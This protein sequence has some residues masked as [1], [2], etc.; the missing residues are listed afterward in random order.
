M[1]AH[2]L[3]NTHQPFANNDAS[4]QIDHSSYNNHNSAWNAHMDPNQTA[5][6]DSRNNNHINDEYGHKKS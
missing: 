2:Y 6:L 3:N 5:Y 4:Y 1:D